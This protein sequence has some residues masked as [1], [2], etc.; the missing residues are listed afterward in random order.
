MLRYTFALRIPIRGWIIIISNM[1][2]NPELKDEF[3]TDMDQRMDLEL[4]TTVN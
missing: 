1:Y 2:S 3:R 4:L